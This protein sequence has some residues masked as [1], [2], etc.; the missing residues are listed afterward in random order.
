M[1]KSVNFV[2]SSCNSDLDEKPKKI[3]KNKIIIKQ[4]SNNFVPDIVELNTKKEQANEINKPKLFFTP[5]KIPDFVD[6]KILKEYVKK[7][8]DAN[9]EYFDD[10]NSTYKI[11]NP[12]KAEW[13][14]NKSIKGGKMIG[15]GNTNVDINVNDK[16]GIDVSVLTLRGNHSNE[17]SVMQ[18]FS[19]CNNLDSLFTENKGDEAVKVFKDNLSKKYNFKD[20][21]DKDILYLIFVCKE[22]NVY[23]TCLKLN[24]E[25]VP[26]IKFSN[27]TKSKKTIQLDNCI[28]PK[29][30]NVILYK[31]KKRLEL[32][33]HKD[34]INNN[35]CSV[36]VF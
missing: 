9:K 15:N 30:G 27:F 18:N 28:D 7:D 4:K 6:I 5:Q 29:V 2:D 11:S 17:K 33:L 31:S 34:I 32:R 36:K 1:L 26:N 3:T 13:I 22:K 23:L 12:T 21:I 16:Y 20:G 25:S 19:G 24:L 14:L 8:V 35:E 10:T